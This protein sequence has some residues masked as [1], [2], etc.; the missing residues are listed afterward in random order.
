MH[1]PDGFLSTPVWAV[2]NAGSALSIGALARRVESTMEEGR[3]PLLGVMGAF[4]FAAQIVNFP[5]GAGAS[6]HLLGGALM[7]VTLGPG[8]ASIVMTAILVVQALVFQDGGLLA[9]GANVCNMALAGVWAGYLPYKYLAAGGWRRTGVFLGGMV[10][11]LCASCLAIA[12][13]RLSGVPMPGA[14][15]GISLGVFLASSI[16]EGSITAT[17]FFAIERMNP[18]WIRPG[19]AEP[20]RLRG[21]LAA[22]AVVLA[23]IGGL[24][25]SSLPDGLEKLAGDLGIAGQARGLLDTPLADYEIQAAAEPW[26]RKAGAGLIG[27]ASVWAL[28]LILARFLPRRE[29]S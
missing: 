11:A 26:M 22:A 24:L 10:S 21:L 25:A 20:R 9:L 7:A 29:R 27:L 19:P 23:S 2:L 13:L 12:E 6:G 18:A 16:L 15:L 14:V 3:A 4:V 5:V 28:C 17:V 1:I 8:A